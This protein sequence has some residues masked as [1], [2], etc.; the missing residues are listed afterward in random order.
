MK[1]KTLKILL[2]VMILLCV[3]SVMVAC[4]EEGK[5]PNPPTTPS[6]PSQPPVDP[7]DV[8]VPDDPVEEVISVT[9]MDGATNKGAFDNFEDVFDFIGNVAP[10]TGYNFVGWFSDEDLTDEITT[11][12]EETFKGLMTDGALTVYMKWEKKTFT[13]R[14]EDLQGNVLQVNGEDTQTVAYGE[15]AVAPE[16]PTSTDA[17]KVFKGWT[18]DFSEVKSDLLVKPVFGGKEATIFLYG[19]DGTL[20]A[21]RNV[22]IGK[23]K[24]TAYSELLTV[25]KKSVPVGLALSEEEPFCTDIDCYYTYEDAAEVME[26]QDVHLYSKVIIPAIGGLE[27]LASRD[28]FAYDGNGFTLT[29]THSKDKIIIYTYEWYNADTG[30]SIYD[31]NETSVD[32]SALDVGQYNYGIKVTASFSDD[33]VVQKVE[34]ITAS[35]EKLI[36]INEGSL[37]FEG[38]VAQNITNTVYNGLARKV[39]IVNSL[40]TDTIYYKQ[41]TDGDEA[42]STVSVI[43]N[44][45]TYNVDIKLERPNYIPIE[46]NQI[47]VNIQ[48]APLTFTTKLGVPGREDNDFYNIS[49]GEAAPKLNYHIEGFVNGE[50]ESVFAWG[51]GPQLVETYIPGIS[52][53]TLNEQTNKDTP[54]VIGYDENQSWAQNNVNYEFV[55]WNM[56]KLSVYKKQVVLTAEN[57]IVTYG[58]TAPVYTVSILGAFPGEEEVISSV[59]K[60]QN[61]SGEKVYTQ[62]TTGVGNYK[63]V[64]SLDETSA[65]YAAFNEK[66]TVASKSVLE[67][68]LEVIPRVVTLR[69][70]N[71]TTMYGE[72]APEFTY[73]VQNKYGEDALGSEDM[74]LVCSYVKGNYVN[75]YD[76]T[77]TDS[78]INNVNYS[79]I[80]AN[81]VL[82]V[83]KRPVTLEFITEGA[84]ALQVQYYDDY[85]TDAMFKTMVKV[86][87]TYGLYGENDLT[88]DILEN[89]RFISSY[90][91]GEPVSAE[92]YPVT[93]SGYSTKNYD[94]TVKEGSLIVT[95][96]TLDVYIQNSTVVYGEEQP[97]LKV[98]LDGL[99]GADK[100]DPEAILNLVSGVQTTYVQGMAPQTLTIQAAS[101]SV[102]LENYV[103][104][105][106]DG[107]LTITKRPLVITARG[108]SADTSNPWSSA[109]EDA[110][111]TFTVSGLYENDVVTDKG[112]LTTSSATERAY[113]LFGEQLSN[114]FIWAENLVVKDKNAQAEGDVA[115]T[116]RYVLTYDIQ[117]AITSLGVFVTSDA[118]Y[119]DGT[120][121]EINVQTFITGMTVE[122]STDNGLSYSSEV[123]QLTNAGSYVVNYVIKRDGVQEGEAQTVM[124]VINPK[125]IAVSVSSQNL[126]YGDTI[127]VS[128]FVPSLAEGSTLVEGDTLESLG[129]ACSL[130]DEGG[131]VVELKS[132]LNAGTYD[133]KI[134]ST[135][136]TNYAVASVDGV[137]R[138]KRKD[139]TLSA[140]SYSIVYGQG[141]DG[142][143]LTASG[144]LPFA[145]QIEEGGFVN[146]ESLASLNATVLFN[147]AYTNNTDAVAGAYD[148][149]PRLALDN[150]NV[151]VNKGTLTVQARDI[152][153]EFGNLEIE[154]G[155]EISDINVTLKSGSLAAW[156]KTGGS[157][158]VVDISKVGSLSLDTAYK[159]GEPAG[160][161]YDIAISGVSKKYNI[162]FTSQ[163]GKVDVIPKKVNL[164][165]MGIAE[166]TYD[167]SD[168][169]SLVYA[170]YKDILDNDVNAIVVFNA[171][172]STPDR[173]LNA[174]TYTVTASTLDGN[175][176]LVNA[177]TSIKV[178][179][180][181][182]TLKDI[183]KIEAP[184]LS[185]VYSPEKTLEDYSKDLTAGF[186]WA[187][188]S[189]G[190]VPVV[191]KTSYA[192]YYNGDKENYNDYTLDGITLEISPALVSLS[193]DDVFVL[194]SNEIITDFN[195]SN[196][197]LSATYTLNPEIW[198][199][200][201]KLT[202]SSVDT[203]YTLSFSNGT[204]FTP[205][206]HLTKMTFNSDNY[207]LNVQNSD[208]NVINF[209][210]KYRSVEV[211]G[212]NGLFTL[213][214]ALNT[215][216]SG[217]V[218]VRAN[219]SF[220]QDAEV[221]N[222]LYNSTSYYTVKTG[223]TLLFPYKA[224]DTQGYVGGGES[225]SDNYE[226]H[227][228]F[229]S[230]DNSNSPP[231]L[232]LTANIPQGVTL[233]VQ[234]TLTVGALTGRQYQGRY[235]NAVTG[236]YAQ[237]NLE[238]IIELNNA[239]LNVYGYI[240]GSGKV[241]AKG[242]SQI[243]ENM[244]LSGWEGGTISAARF[245][246]NETISAMA[247]V[248]GGDLTF[249][250]PVMFP[251]NQYQL[252]AIQSTLEINY[253][254]SLRGF[255]KIATSEQGSGLV[256]AKINT[257]YFNFI[258]SNVNDAS[259][260]LIRMTSSTDKVVKSFNGTK[261]TITLDGNIKDGYTSLDVGVGKKTVK[262]TSEKVFFPIH[263]SID[264]VI[265]S[266]TFTQTYLFKLLPGSTLTVKNGATYNVNGK[267]IAYRTGFTDSAGVA[268][269]YTGDAYVKVEGT[270]NVNG[271]FGGYIQGINGGTVNIASGA[272]ITGIKSIEGKGT[273][274]RSGLN[275]EFTFTEYTA[276][277]QTRDLELKNAS[278]VT[279]ASKGGSYT[280]SN[281]AWA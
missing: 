79:V 193:K 67:A 201:T 25:A 194:V 115:I 124:V 34:S 277:S 154:Y 98:K 19:Y 129:I 174:G 264:I 37:E 254:S 11:Y 119:Y 192:A 176:Q 111:N 43:K 9:F 4:G 42:Y 203:T 208:T 30:L 187:E 68:N 272:T 108:Y 212:K 184:A 47:S 183:L 118:K 179:K 221:R 238:G 56:I 27:V 167:G 266:G 69:I 224:G 217:A 60:Y 223:V 155:S 163:T 235:Q 20:L 86:T 49:Y 253:G 101:S 112:V 6:T 206:T 164:D 145:Y 205:G 151:T 77:V 17:N 16:E 249:D 10:K 243:T 210:V 237:I 148:I 113:Y 131:N 78:S 251:F 242:S 52:K 261:M 116:S 50:D 125:P 180:A 70:D 38:L 213:E 62:G 250:D 39:E 181:N 85:P 130:Y 82:K 144:D 75:N 246:G 186:Y 207:K 57:K 141:L 45:G 81:G 270:L 28:F 172:N 74:T 156:D 197:N 162:S 7:D 219:T 160:K 169:S 158:S 139:L 15:A 177:A 96:K 233:N 33:N 121:N 80:V 72:N 92:G 126:T 268:Y 153:L 150:Y 166:Y 191:K 110:N 199:G 36:T 149:I 23:S 142:K 258:S 24:R 41:A 73:S 87:G 216:T 100:D 255:V 88:T 269:T 117:V 132:I 128:Q 44:A 215:A 29:G 267:T 114:E 175:Y 168:R 256:K 135:T 226:A 260:G 188:L 209:F 171:S 276:Q 265:N 64:A 220:A 182:Y 185:G 152:T 5:Q 8:I 76:I 138:I 99:V 35:A 63:I 189:L 240:K 227:P 143:D 84:N 252:R 107:Q 165:W 257:A 83:N 232:Y 22:E 263:G 274:T 53:I 21:Q 230:E 278:G 146:G 236:G 97:I 40:P 259:S 214:D 122:F 127:D 93:I 271:S 211:G 13:V 48:K 198:W 280:Y 32:I 273:S 196:T 218:I 14:F 46:L 123:P 71:K 245:M 147:C 2:V 58:E 137:L 195:T 31:A 222:T 225:G 231:V 3:V 12:D 91:K 200:S 262:V 159:K 55:E 54:Y 109:I 244:Y 161:T 106:H 18:E 94:V 1:H 279:S 229:Q 61:Q 95:K 134:S 239:T 248:S 133:V 190:E 26:D 90:A 120:V 234:G 247:F 51:E 59:L 103:P 136:S 173:L 89:A 102:T 204:T 281:N 105:F 157:A 104:V 241:V 202:A 178:N 170:T 228:S 66:Y 275:Y 65:N 140:S